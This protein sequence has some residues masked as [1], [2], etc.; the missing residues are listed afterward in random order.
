[1]SSW[2]ENLDG[3]DAEQLRQQLR[4]ETDPKTVKRLAVALLYADGFAPN[5]IEQLLGV[6]VQTA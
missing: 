2:S 3:V 6:P 1:M 4:T 5:Q